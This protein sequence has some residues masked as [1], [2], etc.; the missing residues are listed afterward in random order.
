LLFSK[1]K[2]LVLFYFGYLSS[3]VAFSPIQLKVRKD[4]RYMDI[5]IDPIVAEYE[6]QYNDIGQLMVSMSGY[7]GFVQKNAILEILS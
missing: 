2:Y 3:F 1:V 7:A 6:F 4:V 5:Y